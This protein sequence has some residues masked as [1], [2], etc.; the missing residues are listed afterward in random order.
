M[1][2]ESPPAK[3]R[4]STGWLA[5]CL[6]SSSS[7]ALS[8]SAV[9]AFLFFFSLGALGICE[10]IAPQERLLPI[11]YCIKKF[12]HLHLKLAIFLEGLNPVKLKSTLA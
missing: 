10:S 8:P 7:L 3:S 9:S 12:I 11:F 5:V 4:I 6:R 1:G 2:S